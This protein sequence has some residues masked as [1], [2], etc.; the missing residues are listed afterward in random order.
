MLFFWIKMGCF[1]KCDVFYFTP[2][3]PSILIQKYFNP[4]SGQ[5]DKKSEAL[6]FA[7]RTASNY[8]QTTRARDHSKYKHACVHWTRIC[9]RI[10]NKHEI[11]NV[12][13]IVIHTYCY[14]F[15]CFIID[16]PN[17]VSINCNYKCLIDVKRIVF[18][19]KYLYIYLYFL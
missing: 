13:C 9:A 5:T 16:S 1:K 14:L 10:I 17:C 8:L 7:P 11:T 12:K 18:D 15:D 4:R 3:S 19:W 6:Y 2:R